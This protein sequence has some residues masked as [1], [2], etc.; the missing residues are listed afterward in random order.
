MN[1]NITKATWQQKTLD[2]AYTSVGIAVSSL[3]Q[4]S[5]VTCVFSEIALAVFTSRTLMDNNGTGDVL[6]AKIG[7]RD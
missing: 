5:D 7:A 1:G 6:P 2:G 3:T 4:E